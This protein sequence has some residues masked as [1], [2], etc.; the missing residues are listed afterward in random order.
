MNRVEGFTLIETLVTIVVV[1]IGIMGVLALMSGVF[2]INQRADTQGQAVQLAQLEFDTLKRTALSKVPA[3]GTVDRTVNYSGR[4]FTV[5]QRYCV[6]AAYCIGDQ[7]SVQMD[8]LLNNTVM[9]TGETVLT[10]LRAK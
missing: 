7:R 8:I 2:N 5:R 10:E 9:F 1:T 4:D 6:T 3:T